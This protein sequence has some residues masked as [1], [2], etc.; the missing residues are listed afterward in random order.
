MNKGR[1]LVCLAF[2][3]A[4]CNAIEYD[5]CKILSKANQ[6]QLEWK[7][8]TDTLYFRLSSNPLSHHV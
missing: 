4:V 8:V 2:L 1:L 7:I 6:F 5:N 3:L